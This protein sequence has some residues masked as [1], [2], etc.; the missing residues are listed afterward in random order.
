MERTAGLLALDHGTGW[1]LVGG[2]LAP[3][4]VHSWSEAEQAQA[5]AFR[6]KPGPEDN[7][8]PAPSWRALLTKAEAS[9]LMAVPNSCTGWG[10]GSC[11]TPS[12]L[13]VFVAWL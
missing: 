12:C 6:R 1:A 13:F 10:Q 4:S 8:Q 3:E 2:A 9:Y 7:T 5:Q 11:W